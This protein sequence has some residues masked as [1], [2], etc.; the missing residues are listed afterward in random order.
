M[1]AEI[2]L[3]IDDGSGSIHVE[4]VGGDLTIP[5]AGSGSIHYCGIT[6]K[7]NFPKR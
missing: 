2:E 3:D 6:G 5:G 7:A 1:P 4:D